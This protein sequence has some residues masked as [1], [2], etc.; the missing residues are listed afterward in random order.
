MMEE[1]VGFYNGNIRTTGMI[2]GCCS[3]LEKGDEVQ[4]SKFMS[5][6]SDERRQ[7]K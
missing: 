6:Q 1:D 7:I 2:S 4:D 5:F 3:G